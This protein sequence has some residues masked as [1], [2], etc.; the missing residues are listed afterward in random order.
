MHSRER[1]ATVNDLTEIKALIGLLCIARLH[2][3]GKLNLKDQG[4]S[5]KFRMEIFGFTMT[6]LLFRFLLRVGLMAGI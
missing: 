2:K 5:D 3:A 6:L 4:A 1:D